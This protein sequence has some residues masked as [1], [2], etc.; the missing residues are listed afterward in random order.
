MNVDIERVFEVQDSASGSFVL[1]TGDMVFELANTHDFRYRW[2]DL[3]LW[4][5]PDKNNLEPLTVG[6]RA[7]DPHV[8]PDGRTVVFSRND[9]AQSRLAFVDLHTRVVTEVAPGEDRLGQVFSP[10]WAPDSRRV[11]YS[12]WREGGYRDIYVYDRER[13]Q[14]TRITADR[15]LDTEPSWTPDGAYILFSSDRDHVFNIYAYEVESGA[16]RQVTNVI[17]GAFEPVVSND[18]TRVAYIGFSAQGYDLWAMKLDPAEFFEP[19]PVQDDLPQIDDPT[20]TRGEE[21]PLPP[22]SRRYQAIRTLFPRTILPAAVDIGSSVF[23]TEIGAHAR[24][25]VG[26]AELPFDI[27]V[28]IE[29]EVALVPTGRQR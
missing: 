10:R 5:G 27:P 7:R 24:S 20:P 19:L 3:V 6:A 17:G 4:R 29:A 2:N 11:A 21:R 12:G 26:M 9:N 25:A 22:R 18:G 13:E 23:G 15:F 28:E 14:T 8:S 1:G 16:L